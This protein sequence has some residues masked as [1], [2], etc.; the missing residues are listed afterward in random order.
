MQAGAAGTDSGTLEDDYAAIEAAVMETARGRWFLHEYAARNRQA[1]THAILDA[2]E[3][4]ERRVAE[5]LS[6]EPASVD[7]PIVTS[8]ELLTVSAELD[9]ANDEIL[10]AA[11]G[12]QEAVWTMHEHGTAPRQC[13]ELGKHA[14]TIHAACT[15]GLALFERL[16]E[17]V[18][19]PQ[20]ADT[21]AAAAE[22][23]SA[24]DPQPIDILSEFDMVSPADVDTA[25]ADA[26]AET[27]ETAP[28]I[29]I[30]EVEELD[31]VDPESGE[32]LAFRL[33]TETARQALSSSDLAEPAETF[34]GRAVA[35][36]NAD[37]QDVDEQPLAFSAPGR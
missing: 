23:P 20:A 3:R 2:I 19:A 35:R 16:R 29:E 31:W 5:N 11:E 28:E 21:P 12:I 32:P 37:G 8:G 36:F 18:Q 26:L 15:A 6:E 24:A 4:L 17:A 27:T 30:R 25:T 13:E 14:A 22:V 1:D 7:G 33:D 34:S 9:A 10:D